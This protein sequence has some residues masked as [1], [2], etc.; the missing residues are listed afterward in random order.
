M[1][2]TVNLDDRALAAAR[3]RA[4]RR[5]ISLGEALSEL[6]LLGYD[7]DEDSVRPDTGFPMLPS[8]DGHTITAEMVDA[9][10]DES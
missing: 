5:G 9:A 4:R 3:G 2:T 10:L 8:V 6:A 1:R 7:A